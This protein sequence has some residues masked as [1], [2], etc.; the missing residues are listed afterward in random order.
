LTGPAS[1][2]ENINM[3]TGRA[4]MVIAMLAVPPICVLIRWIPVGQRFKPV[5]L[6]PQNVNTALERQD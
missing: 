6:K 1:G 4:L 2:G 3:R 5:G